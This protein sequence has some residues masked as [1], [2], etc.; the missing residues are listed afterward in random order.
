MIINQSSMLGSLEE[1]P[2]PTNSINPISPIHPTNPANST[3]SVNPKHCI[4][5]VVLQ[6][7]NDSQKATPKPKPP[8]TLLPDACRGLCQA[9]SR[10]VCL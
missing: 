3:N 6:G 5:L 8:Q 1:N 4:T 7:S 2:N 10:P 9:C